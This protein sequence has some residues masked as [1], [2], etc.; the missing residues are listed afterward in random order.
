MNL[1]GASGH[2]KVVIDILMKSNQN[3]EKVFDDNEGIKEILGI[4][5][6]STNNIISSE[7]IISI[8][9]N[10]IRK[11][12]SNKLNSTFGKAIHPSSIID[13]TVRIEGG[14]VVMAGATI[15]S[16]TTVAKHCIV[17]TSSSIDHDCV[18]EDFV[19]ISPNST[20]CGNVTIGEGTHVGAGAGA[21]IIPGVKV[22]KWVTV[23]AGSVVIK[24]VEDGTT[25]V[26]N[27]ARVIKK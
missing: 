14:T 12:I 11:D 13:S 4:S 27:P 22:G 6:F 21:V 17:N 9:N 25:V 10:K 8:G 26:G 5:V 24:D 16:S 23:G 20:L 18:L 3:I 15:N 2:A 1:Y 7:L 19:H